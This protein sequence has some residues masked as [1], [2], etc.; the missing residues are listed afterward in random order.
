MIAARRCSCI[1]SHIPSPSCRCGRW[2]PWRRAICCCSSCRFQW[3]GGRGQWYCSRC[4]RPRCR[5]C[6]A[7]GQFQYVSASLRDHVDTQSDDDLTPRLDAQDTGLVVGDSSGLRGLP[8]S[9]VRE[10]ASADLEELSDRDEADVDDVIG[11]LFRGALRP[12]RDA[13]DEDAG[14]AM[15]D[16]DQ[17]GVS[18]SAGGLSGG[19]GVGVSL[20]VSHGVGLVASLPPPSFPPP[21]LGSPSEI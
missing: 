14:L 21:L 16:D 18:G 10:A 1:A 12:D 20:G 2:C 4:R 17:V 13:F 3:S 11:E 7:C 15:G 9:A 8:V 5:R 19:L 6:L